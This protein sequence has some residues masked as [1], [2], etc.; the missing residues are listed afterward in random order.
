VTANSSEPAVAIHNKLP[1]W[2]ELES[3]HLDSDKPLTAAVAAHSTGAVARLLIDHTVFDRWSLAI[4]EKELNT[5]IEHGLSDCIPVSSGIFRQETDGEAFIERVIHSLMQVKPLGLR[6]VDRQITTAQVLNI[7]L[8]QSAVK[9]LHEC[10]A[11]LGVTTAAA[12]L[13]LFGETAHRI[14]GVPALSIGITLADRHHG[15]DQ[16]INCNVNTLPFYW[17]NLSRSTLDE[18]LNAVSNRLIDYV[19]HSYIGISSIL[20]KV[21]ELRGDTTWNPYDIAFGYYTE[22]VSKAKGSVSAQFVSNPCAR[23][24]LT[25]WIEEKQGRLNLT[26]TSHPKYFDTSDLQRWHHEYL[27]VI[28]E[29]SKHHSNENFAYASV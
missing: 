15:N 20:N 18:R 17:E 19:S 12:A 10:S 6:C 27:Q 5:F 11:K 29:T 25:L 28:I 1:Q 26:W 14:M 16:Y 2:L 24:P 13:G 7:E 22:P 4:L 8:P 9:A 23:L 21:R 3:R